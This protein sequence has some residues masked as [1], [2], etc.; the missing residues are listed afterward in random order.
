VFI[1]NILT[2]FHIFICIS[3]ADEI[4]FIF[5]T[6]CYMKQYQFYMKTVGY[7]CSLWFEFSISFGLLF[8]IVGI[9]KNDQEQ[10]NSNGYYFNYEIEIFLWN[11]KLAKIEIGSL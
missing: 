1:E 6:V 3:L 10:L 9:T 2:I 5:N 4:L 11:N 8:I 7:L